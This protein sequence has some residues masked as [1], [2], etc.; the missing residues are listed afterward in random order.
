MTTLTTAAEA[1][2]TSNRA[3]AEPSAQP[4]VAP[5]AASHRTGFAEQQPPRATVVLMG[6]TLQ[7]ASATDIGFTALAEAH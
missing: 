1:A 5:V 4:R 2:L 7:Q 3:E 6:A